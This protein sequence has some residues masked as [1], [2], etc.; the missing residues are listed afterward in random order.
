VT[1]ENGAGHPSGPVVVERVPD[2]C[3]FFSGW[4][5]P[6]ELLGE[7]LLPEADPEALP[8]APPEAE[9]DPDL[10]GS[11]ALG[12]LEL[13]DELDELDELGELGEV[14]DEP[15]LEGGVELALPLVLPLVL[16]PLLPAD[17]PEPV[18]WPQAA[19]PK[20]KATAA[21]SVESFM[22]PPWLGIRKKAANNGPGPSRCLQR[23]NARHREHLARATEFLTCCPGS[24][25]NAWTNP[26]SRSS[27]P[28]SYPCCRWS[29]TS[30]RTQ[31][32]RR[33]RLPGRIQRARLPA[34]SKLPL[35]MPLLSCSPPWLETQSNG[36]KEWTERAAS[37][38]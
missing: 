31:T 1:K 2:Y 16:L 28:G 24:W 4:V 34:P 26:V 6:D 15:E 27:H 37:P 18:S 35:P 25:S 12:E 8:L 14:E 32:S 36:S 13:G 23:P 22:C 19:R 11:V 30:R 38:R 5:A 17:L 20:A 29:P 10:E 7:E 21:A 9:P 33:Q 3:D